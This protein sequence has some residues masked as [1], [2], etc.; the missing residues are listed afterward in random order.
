MRPQHVK[1]EV[2]LVRT[3]AGDAKRVARLLTALL[4][5]GAL[6][7]RE[8]VIAIRNDVRLI[9]RDLEGVEQALT[10]LDSHSVTNMRAEIRARKAAP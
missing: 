4:D 3:C 7:T 8:Q 10:P 2:H 1:N 5:R 6:P 9:G